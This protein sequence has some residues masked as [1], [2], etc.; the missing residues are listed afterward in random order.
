MQVNLFIVE[1][2]FLE[3]FP[4]SDMLIQ[5]YLEHELMGMSNGNWY[6]VCHLL[7]T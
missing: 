3:P 4:I 7:K 1:S 6:T 5:C 2:L